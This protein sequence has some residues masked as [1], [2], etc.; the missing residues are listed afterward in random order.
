MK[1]K[2]TLHIKITAWLVL[3]A[4]IVAL[5]PVSQKP[6]TAE[7]TVTDFNIVDIKLTRGEY[8]IGSNANKDLI[9]KGEYYSNPN[10]VTSYHTTY[11]YFHTQD[12]NGRPTSSAA[13]KTFPVYVGKHESVPSATRPGYV[14]DTYYVDHD[15]LKSMITT[16]YSPDKLT[17]EQTVYFSEGFQVKTRE[18]AKSAWKIHGKTYNTLED[19]RNAADWSGTTYGNFDMY[20]DAQITL[21]LDDLFKGAKKKYKLEVE[22]EGNGIVSGSLGEFE[23]GTPVYEIASPDNGWYLKEWKGNKV[24]IEGVDWDEETI[25]FNMPARDVKLIAVFEEVDGSKPEPTKKPV[26][27]TL[28]PE[29]DGGGAEIAPL[30]T[31]TPAP[32]PQ[33]AVDLKR[34][35]DFHRYYTTDKGYS[36]DKL[37]DAPV[38]YNRYGSNAYSSLFREKVDYQVGTDTEGNEWYFYANG[39]AATY[40]HPKKYKGYD[41]RSASIKYIEELTF[42]EKL[43]SGSTTYTVISIGGGLS[44]YGQTTNPPPANSSSSWEQDMMSGTYSYYLG[45][46]SEAVTAYDYENLDYHF[47]VLGNGV[48]NSS[49]G[50]YVLFMTT[51]KEQ[52]QLYDS[53]YTV[54]NTTLKVI[55]IPKSVTRIEDYA[56]A[57]CN[58]L[59]KIEGGDG[60]RII[61]EHAFEG[62]SMELMLSGGDGSNGSKNYISYNDSY[63]L[64]LP[65]TPVMLEYDKTRQLSEYLPLAPFPKLETIRESAF[66]NRSNLFDVTMS[67]GLL[68]IK[69]DAFKGCKLNTIEIPGVATVIEGER[70]TLGTKGYTTENVK[71]QII[72]QPEST[73]MY[74]GLLYNPYYKVR[75]GYEVTYDNNFDP[76]ETFVT[77]AELAEHH[78]EEVK[79]VYAL[80]KGGKHNLPTDFA[81]VTLDPDGNVWFRHPDNV[82]PELLDFGCKVADIEAVD[83]TN[84]LT[85]KYANGS[86]TVVVPSAYIYLE[87][88][89]V[90]RFDKI[91]TDS[92]DKDTPYKSSWIKLGVP[93]GASQYYWAETRTLFQSGTSGP[94]GSSSESFSAKKYLYYLTE[95]GT[96]ECVGGSVLNTA[97]RMSVT[98]PAGITFRSISIAETNN[99]GRHSV[100]DGNVYFSNTYLPTIY[101]VDT[102]GEYWTGTAG[103]LFADDGTTP[104]YVKNESFVKVSHDDYVWEKAFTAGEKTV[105]IVQTWNSVVLHNTIHYSDSG[106]ARENYSRFAITDEGNLIYLAHPYVYGY[107]NET[108]QDAN[109]TSIKVL[110]EG[111]FTGRYEKEGYTFLVDGEGYLW[112]FADRPDTVPVKLFADADIE[113]IYSMAVQS[114][115]SSS[116]QTPIKTEVEITLFDEKNRMWDISYYI[117]LKS[118]NTYQEISS[119]TCTQPSLKKTATFP[120]KVKKV[121]YQV[122]SEGLPY[123]WSGS[124]GDPSMLVLLENGTIYAYGSNSHAAK[125]TYTSSTGYLCI[126]GGQGLV[127]P[128]GVTFVDIV[129]LKQYSLALD[130]DGNV[131]RAG[132]Y[133]NSQGVMT[134]D[135]YQRFTLVPDLEMEYSESGSFLAGYHF[136]ER[137][138]DNM[139]QRDGYTFLNW[140]LTENNS[141]SPLYPDEELVVEGPTRIYANW[142]KTVNKVRYHPNG[143]SGHMEDSV[144]D[145]LVTRKV[146]L[147]ECLFIKDGHGFIGWNT[148]KDGTGTMYQP[149]TEY[150]TGTRTSTTLYAQ[151]APLDYT[152]HVAGNEV[153]VRPVT[154]T[155]HE[156]SYNEEF[157][158]PAAKP[159]R[160]FTVDY[161]L[162][163]RSTM[164]TTPVWKTPT[165]FSDNYTKAKLKFIG[166]ELWEEIVKDTEYNYLNRLYLPG[167]VDKNFARH[168][169]Y[170]PFLFP[171]WGG[172]DAYVDL[173]VAV[174]DG[175]WFVGYTTTAT[176]TDEENVIHAEDGSGAMYKPK[177]NETLY[178]YYEPKQYEIDLV[179]DV[180]DAEP[181]EITETQTE[182]LMTFDNVLPTVEIPQS[183]I[184]I[185]MGYYDKLDADGHPITE[186]SGKSTQYYDEYGNPCLD[187]SGNPLV[188]RIHDESV[189]KLYAYFISEI[190]VTLDGRG[191]TKQE[192]KSVIMTYDQVGPDVIPPEKTGYTFQ[193]YYTGIRGAGKRYFDENGK[194]CA[195][196]LEKRTNILYAYWIQDPVEL[197]EKDPTENPDVLPEDRVVIEASLDTS[198]VQI[199]ADDND[200][201]TGAMTDVQPYLVSDVVIDGKVVAEG[202]I[203][204]T[205]NVA[206][207]AKM[208]AWMLS[209]VLER[210]SGVDY[211]RVYVTV[212][213][214]TQ[215]EDE[216]TEELIISDILHATY[217]FMIPKAWSYWVVAD[218]GIY[219]PEKVV[220]E[221]EALGEPIEIPVKWTSDGAMA[222]PTYQ[223]KAYGEK[224]S[225]LSF[226]AYDSDG[227][228]CLSLTA[229]GVQYII[230]DKPGEL[231]NIVDHLKIIGSN[232]AWADNTQFTVKSDGFSVAGETLLSDKTFD[233]GNGAIPDSVA[234]EK[235]KSKITLTAYS[236]AYVSGI[237]IVESALN[238]CYDTVAETVYKADSSNEGEITEIREEVTEVNEVNVHTPVVCDGI[239]TTDD[240]KYGD[241]SDVGQND[242]ETAIV[243]LESYFTPFTVSIENQGSHRMV[244]GYG[245]KDFSYALSGKTNLATEA[246]GTLLNQVRFPFDVYFDKNTDS[247]D[248][249]AENVDTVNDMFIPANTWV[250][251]GDSN[252]LFY[253]PVTQKTGEY[254]IEF[255]TVAVNCPKDAEGRYITG[256]TEFMANKDIAKYIATD[257]LNLSIK[258]GIMDLVLTGTND[259]TAAQKYMSGADILTMSKGYY[260]NYVIKTAGDEMT[261][262]DAEIKITPSYDYIT[263][264]GKYRTGATIYYNEVVNGNRR[265]YVE[266]GSSLDEQNMHS[267]SNRNAVL[268]IPSSL[269][270]LT[271]KIERETGFAGKL[272]EMF[273]FSDIRFGRYLRMYP[274][275][276]KELFPVGYCTSCFRAYLQGEELS[277]GHES[278]LEKTLSLE[279]IEKAVQDWYGMFYLPAESF[280]VTDDTKEGYCFTCKKKRYVR[281]GKTLC[282]EHG[283]ELT[284][285]RDFDFAV[286]A[287]NATISG[288]EEFFVK[289]GYLAISYDVAMSNGA[290]FGKPYKEWEELELAKRWMKSSFVYKVGDIVL[291]RLDRTIFDDYE[292]GGT[293]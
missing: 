252:A 260:Y 241:R 263:S 158:I 205:E 227:V 257:S 132:Y 178:A 255:R 251:I 116:S 192:Q 147:S 11:I 139:F 165:P 127:S 56:F 2:E 151:W 129:H 84:S 73:A 235:V 93:V 254:V 210:R 34:D 220:V 82:L 184:Y 229:P 239:I 16:L 7:A 14:Q 13:G 71:T 203:P 287:S 122:V 27:V 193:G 81:T 23:A 85:Y 238:A 176:E 31:P 218:G 272:T 26:Q 79:T 111:N 213:Y 172:E 196:W 48:M 286:Y 108:A 52:S 29:A 130:I 198:T 83:K 141:D 148:K 37:A 268:N 166:W 290:T 154:S 69:A 75:C 191:A 232:T 186:G 50:I 189:T 32:T 91:T 183:D 62:G 243:V 72:T 107:A 109:S 12:S 18:D 179:V 8:F 140:N 246:S 267:Y 170:D 88:G 177:G 41:V 118:G 153:R 157:T 110:Y 95:S 233:D 269:L 160:S 100:R 64:T 58:A 270:E 180:E 74:Y 113:H 190:E 149:G 194:G 124:G 283:I 168:K 249:S 119:Y 274:G 279:G 10:A 237:S 201:A 49:S 117:V 245:Q 212:P 102:K 4:T 128:S 293:E 265:R 126:I 15:T 98:M 152:L 136:V 120:S 248:V 236:Q 59:V 266:I 208:G 36:I 6:E 76:E 68:T 25:R 216:E 278:A 20:Y 55:T 9:I 207:R 70:H 169:Q 17:G 202:A 77:T 103:K 281:E 262:A 228:P 146:I 80:G 167:Q 161:R 135:F 214:Q 21:N 200:P 271:E 225:H 289:E 40:V 47:G 285:L 204:S 197:P 138:Y 39:N 256:V 264:D 217:S 5:F 96:I 223:L 221:N 60:I 61:G 121:S 219:F 125:D 112:F 144:C 291:Y 250:S 67:E 155:S 19:I 273:T 275:L 163:R 134:P 206:I 131:Y 195:V 258:S 247:F 259:K 97:R 133:Q 43:V 22:E 86:D 209:S 244:I 284:E 282:P 42:P 159:D 28:S 185:F 240:D 226:G 57:N 230:S 156:L 231:P 277:C 211:V 123:G 78:I 46:S 182:V 215:Y 280:V 90:Y 234:I 106:Y 164:S 199:Y 38:L 288:N 188:W 63:A 24:G 94:Y 66:L 261:D 224:D 45:K 292:I 30:P 101:A 99:G 222:K 89:E 44:W 65:Y 276:K 150:N 181:G 92:T 114:S 115:V 104:M 54:Y 35:V 175:Y 143:A 174:C 242:E 162:N 173:P 1:H 137:L 105:N 53:S 3:F 142:E 145:P 253:I 187:A 51:G 33:P 171:Y 87:S